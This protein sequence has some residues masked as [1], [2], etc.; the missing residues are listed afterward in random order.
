[1]GIIDDNDDYQLID[2]DLDEG[3]N[4]LVYSGSIKQIHIKF[5]LDSEDTWGYI[6]IDKL[7]VSTNL[8]IN[9]PQGYEISPVNFAF[10][11][12]TTNINPNPIV[13]TIESVSTSSTQSVSRLVSPFTGSYID[14]FDSLP[15]SYF[16]SLS[17]FGLA[18]VSGTPAEDLS[19]NEPEEYF[20]TP[21]YVLIKELESLYA[22]TSFG[23]SWEASGYLHESL[24]YINDQS[25]SI[26]TE[27]TDEDDDWISEAGVKTGTYPAGTKFQIYACSDPFGLGVTIRNF[28][29]SHGA[30]DDEFVIENG[31]FPTSE[32][33]GEYFIGLNDQFD[34]DDMRQ[35]STMYGSIDLTGRQNFQ[36]YSVTTERTTSSES[37]TLLR[38]FTT[39]TAC[40]SFSFSWQTRALNIRVTAYSYLYIDGVYAGVSY[41]GRSSTYVTRSG[42]KS[43]TYPAGTDIAI[44]G[45]VGPDDP[46]WG[47]G[48]CS[49]RNVAFTTYNIEPAEYNSIDI[50][51]FNGDTYLSTITLSGNPSFQF[52][53]R[54]VAPSSAVTKIQV[55]PTFS[56]SYTTITYNSLEVVGNLRDFDD[57]PSGLSYPAEWT[58]EISK[59]GLHTI[60]ECDLGTELNFE[61]LQKLEIEVPFTVDFNLFQ[62]LPNPWYDFG[63][64]DQATQGSRMQ[65][66][67]DISMIYDMDYYNGF[68]WINCDLVSHRSSPLEY[69]DYTT[70]MGL[71]IMKADMS[72][73]TYNV[74]DNTYVKLRL[75]PTIQFTKPSN[76]LFDFG[77]C[78]VPIIEFDKTNT[79][80]ELSYP[81]AS[82]LEEL[83]DGTIPISAPYQIIDSELISNLDTFEAN[84]TTEMEMILK[85][86]GEAYDAN[87][88]FGDNIYPA[89]DFYGDTVELAHFENDLTGGTGSQYE[90]TTEGIVGDNSLHFTGDDGYVKWTTTTGT[91]SSGTM[92]GYFTPDE[93]LNDDIAY[94]IFAAASNSYPS[95]D[96]FLRN[97]LIEAR[98]N[99]NAGWT[100]S[101]ISQTSLVVG[102]T[103]HIAYTWGP[104]GQNLYI[105]NVKED[106]NPSETRS[107]VLVGAMTY[108]IGRV[109]THTSYDG[110]CARGTYDEF[111]FSNTQ[112]TEFP[113]PFELDYSGISELY[114]FGGISNLPIRVEVEDISGHPIDT[115]DIDFEISFYDGSQIITCSS[116]GN[117]YIDLDLSPDTLFGK[118]IPDSFIFKIIATTSNYLT[119]L[120]EERNYE[121]TISLYDETG[122][123]WELLSPLTNTALAFEIDPSSTPFTFIDAYFNKD[124][125]DSS[126]LYERE[127]TYEIDKDLLDD[128]TLEGLEIGINGEVFHYLSN[129]E[130]SNGLDGWN[131]FDMFDSR[132]HSITNNNWTIH[133][134]QN[135]F[136][137]ISPEGTG[138][139][140][141]IITSNFTQ[142]FDET[143]GLR[144]YLYPETDLLDFAYEGENSELYYF[145]FKFVIDQD[146]FI[147]ANFDENVSNFLSVKI[148]KFAFAAVIARDPDDFNLVDFTRY[149]GEHYFEIEL[150]E[151]DTESIILTAELELN[152]NIT[153]LSDIQ[154]LANN[155]KF[156]WTDP[157]ALMYLKTTKN[158]YITLPT[159]PTASL[160]FDD[161]IAHLKFD[162]T[163]DLYSQNMIDEFVQ[164]DGTLK[165]YME[166]Q[167]YFLNN[168][169]GSIISRIN[170]TNDDFVSATAM[171]WE[172]E[173]E[174]LTDDIHEN[175]DIGDLDDDNDLD[176]LM[177]G[178]SAIIIQANT[179]TYDMRLIAY[180]NDTYETICDQYFLASMFTGTPHPEFYEFVDGIIP[181]FSEN[182][183]LNIV[184]YSYELDSVEISWSDTIDGTY[185]SIDSITIGDD[186][187]NYFSFEVNST[188]ESINEGTKY[189][190]VESTNGGSSG[191]SI[192]EA[193]VDK[194][195]PNTS[196]FIQYNQ[197]STIS[198]QSELDFIIDEENTIESF[199][200]NI[201]SLENELLYSESVLT[202][203]SVSYSL[204]DDIIKINDI[205]T[206]D[207]NITF[208]AVDKAG[209]VELVNET[210]IHIDQDYSITFY[211]DTYTAEITVDLEVEYLD[212]IYG[213]AKDSFDQPLP[214]GFDL[215]LE[216]NNITYIRTEINDAEGK[217]SAQILSAD[218]HS[219]DLRYIGDVQIIPSEGYGVEFFQDKPLKIEFPNTERNME[220]D[221]LKRFFPYRSELSLEYDTF[222]LN[223][224]IV[225]GSYEGFRIDLMV[226]SV[227]SLIS[228]STFTRIDIKFYFSVEGENETITDSIVYSISSDRIVEMLEN[229]PD[230]KIW[231]DMLVSV[232][233][234]N[235]PFY[236]LMTLS[237]S[238]YPPL[239]SKI[240]I[241]G[242]DNQIHPEFSFED[243]TY[244]YQVLGCAGIYLL[245]Q[246][247]NATVFYEANP[248]GDVMSYEMQGKIQD[249][250]LNGVSASIQNTMKINPSQISFDTI[251]SN[252]SAIYG[253]FLTVDG[254]SLNLPYSADV[255]GINV[256]YLLLS[257][258]NQSSGEKF[259]IG[260]QL[261]YGVNP[262]TDFM[263]LATPYTYN[264]LTLNFTGNGLFESSTTILSSLFTVQR[265]P[266]LFD[267]AT[268]NPNEVLDFHVERNATRPLSGLLL[269]DDRFPLIDNFNNAQN[270]TFYQYENDQ[271][272]V[273]F[274]KEL[275]AAAII[276]NI[277]YGGTYYPIDYTFL[278]KSE[279]S[280]ISEFFQFDV[281]TSEDGC[282]NRM[283]GT[284][285]LSVE[286]L[287]TTYYNST[288]RVFTVS[289]DPT[290]VAIEIKE[291][292]ADIWHTNS[293]T[294]ITEFTYTDA[295]EFEVRIED[296]YERDVQP[297]T[298]TYLENTPVWLEVGLIPNSPDLEYMNENMKDTW[299]DY[300]ILQNANAPSNLMLHYYQQDLGGK[301]ILY[302]YYDKDSATFKTFSPLYYQ[303]AITDDEGIAQF[304]VHGNVT[305][306]IAQEYL[307]KLDYTV[308]SLDS[309]I[310]YMRVFYSSQFDASF[311]KIPEN[312][313]IGGAYEVD[314]Y[315]NA[316]WIYNGQ[317]DLVDVANNPFFKNGFYADPYHK[318]GWLEGKAYIRKEDTM[319]SVARHDI[320]NAD[321]SVSSMVI[322]A[323]IINDIMVPEEDISESNFISQYGIQFNGHT[324]A[325]AIELEIYNRENTTKIID[326]AYNHDLETYDP[327]VL[328]CD[329]DALNTFPCNDYMFGPQMDRLIPGYYNLH[330]SP[331]LTESVYYNEPTDGYAE[332]E[333]KGPESYRLDAPSHLYSLYD[334][335]TYDPNT[336][337][338]W[339]NSTQEENYAEYD[340]N[341]PLLTGTLDVYSST[342]V[343]ET[344]NFTETIIVDIMLNDLKYDTFYI[345][346]CSAWNESYDF[347]YPLKF[348]HNQNL[349]LTLQTRFE[350]NPEANIDFT[351]YENEYNETHYDT[352][353]N[354]TDWSDWETEIEPIIGYAWGN[355]TPFADYQLKFSN[356]QIEQSQLYHDGQTWAFQKDFEEGTA[357]AQPYLNMT[358]ASTE[359]W[360]YLN[361]SVQNS[362][363][364]LNVTIGAEDTDNMIST[365]FNSSEIVI[366]FD[367]SSILNW[368]SHEN[369]TFNVTYDFR[370]LFTVEMQHWNNTDL[371]LDY[372]M[373]TGF[374]LDNYFEDDEQYNHSVRTGFFDKNEKIYDTTYF[375]LYE[376]ESAAVI[377]EGFFMPWQ[378]E[379]DL[380]VLVPKFSHLNY[381]NFELQ[382]DIYLE[383]QYNEENNHYNSTTL[384][385]A[386]TS[387]YSC[388]YSDDI[389]KDLSIKFP[390]QFYSRMVNMQINVTVLN[391]NEPEIIPIYLVSGY[392][393]GQE[394]IIEI[395]TA[396]P[397]KLRA[398]MFSTN[399]LYF[400]TEYGY[401]IG[402]ENATNEISGDHLGINDAYFELLG[403]NGSAYGVG[404]IKD[405]LN[406][407]DERSYILSGFDNG[408][409][410]YPAFTEENVNEWFTHYNYTQ[411]KR[412]S[413][414]DTY[415]EFGGENDT[416]GKNMAT[417]KFNETIIDD[418]ESPEIY[419]GFVSI[420]DSY[421]D[422]S[423]PKIR[424]T[425]ANTRKLTVFVY[426]AFWNQSIEK[427]G[428]RSSAL[429]NPRN[430]ITTTLGDSEIY[431]NSSNGDYSYEAD[432]SYRLNPSSD[433]I[434]IN[435]WS[436]E[437]YRAGSGLSDIANIDDIDESWFIDDIPEIYDHDYNGQYAIE[438]DTYTPFDENYLE[439]S[440]L[441]NEYPELHFD[442]SGNPVPVSQADKVT[443]SYRFGIEVHSS[444]VNWREDRQL[445]LW[446]GGYAAH[447]Y[448]DAGL[449]DTGIKWTEGEIPVWKSALVE[450]YG[451]YTE[452]PIYFRTIGDSTVFNQF[453]IV[454][455]YLE[456]KISNE[457][458]RLYWDDLNSMSYQDLFNISH[459][460]NSMYYYMDIPDDPYTFYL[461]D[462]RDYGGYINGFGSTELLMTEVSNWKNT[463]WTG[464]DYRGPV[465]VP[466]TWNWDQLTEFEPVY[467]DEV[468]QDIVIFD[469]NYEDLYN[470]YKQPID[471]TSVQYE[472][473]ELPF[474]LFDAQNITDVFIS[475]NY[476][477]DS[478]DPIYLNI[479]SGVDKTGFFYRDL[480]HNINFKD[481]AN[482]TFDFR[483]NENATAELPSTLAFG[484]LGLFTPKSFGI[485]TVETNVT[486]YDY[487]IYPSVFS[488]PAIPDMAKIELEFG[489]EEEIIE[490]LLIQGTE[491]YGLSGSNL[492]LFSIALLE[493]YHYQENE[494]GEAY[495]IRGGYIP[496]ANRTI[497]LVNKTAPTVLYYFDFDESARDLNRKMTDWYRP[498]AIEHIWI[499]TTVAGIFNEKIPW[500][501]QYSI[502]LNGDAN[503]DLIIE[504]FDGE[505]K[506]DF[507]NN[508]QDY[509]K[510]DFGAD[511]VWDYQIL[512]DTQDYLIQ[513]SDPEL[514]GMDENLYGG[515]KGHYYL[516]N[517]KRELIEVSYDTDYD[518]LFDFKTEIFYSMESF[519]L[520]EYR[521]IQIIDHHL[522]QMSDV[523]WNEPVLGIKYSTDSDGDGHFEETMERT[524]R[525]A[526]SEQIM[527]DMY[528]DMIFESYKYS[529]DDFDEEDNM[530]ITNTSFYLCGPDVFLFDERGFIQFDPQGNV[531]YNR[532]EI[533]GDF[534]FEFD[535]KVPIDPRYNATKNNDVYDSDDTLPE[536]LCE[537]NGV[538]AWY[539]TGTNGEKDGKMDIAFV[540]T[541]ESWTQ[542]RMAIGIYY[543]RSGSEQVQTDTNLYQLSGDQFLPIHWLS[544]S[545]DYE[546]FMNMAWED[547]KLAYYN[548]LSG[549]IPGQGNSFTAQYYLDL[550]AGAVI[551]GGA[552]ATG[553]GAS[554]LFGAGIPGV[555][556]FVGIMAAYTYYQYW[557][558]PS[559]ID[560][561]GQ[562]GIWGMEAELPKWDGVP[563]DAIGWGA[564]IPDFTNW[565]SYGEMKY[566]SQ[567]IIFTNTNPWYSDTDWLEDE[568]P[569]TH[570]EIPFEIPLFGIINDEQVAV[571][572]W[573]FDWYFTYQKS[574]NPEDY[575]PNIE[576]MDEWDHYESLL[577]EIQ[578]RFAFD[579]SELLEG[580][581]LPEILDISGELGRDAYDQ[582]WRN[583]TITDDEHENQIGKV[584]KYISTTASYNSVQFGMDPSG[585]PMLVPVADSNRNLSDPIQKEIDY[586]EMSFL[587]CYWKE[588]EAFRTR[589]PGV[590]AIQFGLSV[591]Q[592]MAGVFASNIVTKLINP[593]GFA[594]NY[595]SKGDWLKDF[596]KEILEE[597]IYE[598][599]ISSA[600][601][602][603]GAST[604]FANLLGEAS[605]S[606]SVVQTI[607]SLMKTDSTRA[608]I[609]AYESVSGNSYM[610]LS[611]RISDA[612]K[613]F[614]SRDKGAGKAKIVEHLRQYL[615]QSQGTHIL[616]KLQGNTRLIATIQSVIDKKM[617]ANI[618]LS[619]MLDV[620]NGLQEKDFHPERIQFKDQ[621][622]K[623]MLQDEMWAH[624]M[625]GGSINELLND[626]AFLEKFGCLNPDG[627]VKYYIKLRFVIKGLGT[628][629][630]Y[631]KDFGIEKLGIEGT[632]DN[633][634]TIQYE[635]GGDSKTFVTPDS[636]TLG[637]MLSECSSLMV[638]DPPVLP[639]IRLPQGLA[640]HKGEVSEMFSTGEVFPVAHNV[641]NLR[642]AL[643]KVDRSLIERFASQL[644]DEFSSDHQT[645][646]IP[647]SLTMGDFKGAFKQTLN[648]MIERWRN[649]DPSFK[650]KMESNQM[651]EINFAD[652]T[653][654][655]IN[656]IEK[657]YAE[658]GWNVYFLEPKLDV[659]H[660]FMG[661]ENKIPYKYL[662][663]INFIP[664]LLSRYK[665]TSNSEMLLN[666][667]SSAYISLVE[668]TMYPKIA[669]VLGDS[670]S[671]A[672]DTITSALNYKF[673]NQD[674]TNDMI[675]TDRILLCL[676]YMYY[677][678][679][680]SVISIL[681]KYITS[682]TPGAFLKRYVGTSYEF[683]VSTLIDTLKT[684]ELYFGDS[685]DL[686]LKIDRVFNFVPYRAKIRDMELTLSEKKVLR[687]SLNDFETN[688]RTMTPQDISDFVT[689]TLKVIIPTFYTFIDPSI[690][691]KQII[692]NV[693]T[694]VRLILEDILKIKVGKS[695]N[696][697]KAEVIVSQ[698]GRPTEDRFPTYFRKVINNFAN[699]IFHVPGDNYFNIFTTNRFSDII[700]KNG[701]APTFYEVLLSKSVLKWLTDT[702]AGSDIEKLNNLVNEIGTPGTE[703]HDSIYAEDFIAH[704][705][706]TG[707]KLLSDLPHTP[708][709]YYSTRTSKKTNL[710]H[711]NELSVL[712]SYGINVASF[713]EKSAF[714]NS[715]KYTDGE[716]N[717]QYS[718]Y[719]IRKST[720]LMIDA[721]ADRRNAKAF[722]R[723]F[724]ENYFTGQK[725]G[726]RKGDSPDVKRMWGDAFRFLGM[727]Y[728]KDTLKTIFYETAGVTNFGYLSY[729]PFNLLGQRAQLKMP[730]VCNV[731]NEKMS[732]E[733]RN[734]FLG[735]KYRHLIPTT[736]YTFNADGTVNED[737]DFY[738]S[739]LGSKIIPEISILEFYRDII[740]EGNGHL[741]SDIITD[742][743]DS[744]AAQAKFLPMTH[745]G[746]WLPLL[747]EA[748]DRALARAETLNGDLGIYGPF[749]EGY[750]GF[751]KKL[752]TIDW[753]MDLG[754]FKTSY[755]DR[756][757][758]TESQ[759]KRIV[760]A[761]GLVWNSVPG[762]EI[763]YIGEAQGFMQAK[764][765]WI[766]FANS[767]NE[768]LADG[769]T[770]QYTVDANGDLISGNSE[771]NI[772]S[773]VTFYHIYNH[774][775]D[776]DAGGSGQIHLLFPPEAFHGEGA[777]YSEWTIPTDI[778]ANDW[779]H[780][781]YPGNPSLHITHQSFFPISYLQTLLDNDDIHEEGFYG[782]GDPHNRFIFIRYYLD[783][784]WKRFY[785]N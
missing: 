420:S 523:F 163:I 341:Y 191:Y 11:D 719:D 244:S 213:I 67:P 149:G 260:M 290:D 499:N 503:Y 535:V 630:Y 732:V 624:T 53:I 431:I 489:S 474:Y 467:G 620:I 64:T 265:R 568:E 470:I 570:F 351:F 230:Q 703:L 482:I 529:T 102:R 101:L 42:S 521:R 168:M 295:K 40:T 656:T 473:L 266:T 669:Y 662:F 75:N 378:G 87:I 37:L 416:T 537:E 141:N 442:L 608:L 301:P 113:G 613:S 584:E 211:D 440:F 492:D 296:L 186:M 778:A 772:W 249:S 610:P 183:T 684:I 600:A 435:K 328:W 422:A 755:N 372:Q 392:V 775:T 586:L 423:L 713:K 34:I 208:Y 468:E 575:I 679:R 106:S 231:G 622:L 7:T 690:E 502:D 655:G 97:G 130:N 471:R 651:V 768:H 350:Y 21:D 70:F 781:L 279:E 475:I 353:T 180:N 748:D 154:L 738:V 410:D 400:F 504:E 303:M 147:A 277:I 452:L 264:D 547:S 112:R 251:S 391:S 133:N 103:Y 60:L 404:D 288:E 306:D 54:D 652:G 85:S 704:K 445:E 434:V 501:N 29:I 484:G 749:A 766:D 352:E 701:R 784:V 321:F 62:Y 721:D 386:D 531:L 643:T 711:L 199:S 252:N 331:A 730:V 546:T 182:F 89:L 20:S 710:F 371:D 458:T 770:L 708:S 595:N 572:Q 733:V 763:E 44:Y 649:M 206:P 193:V 229:N 694:D 275:P 340:S 365:Q 248:S 693:I 550:V 273:D 388:G 569:T 590:L 727:I 645:L 640:T 192:L 4:T 282:L 172:R 500:I 443:L 119:Y 117:S 548:Q 758:L 735:L 30:S 308:S 390:E 26:G 745:E 304:S 2:L 45:K 534:I 31:P 329:E 618:D 46:V 255:C 375:G 723:S 698:S 469:F 491:G 25:Q 401:D 592:T 769:P 579:N 347:V 33:S 490:N 581:D 118:T 607:N 562:K 706:F 587:S 479:S 184:D 433:D 190:K 686:G 712:R 360:S 68:E 692:R 316:Q 536:L 783:E 672:E 409:W 335:I 310:M 699:H 342:H 285:I 777:A 641:R 406:V 52:D 205:T 27:G 398:R 644:R 539:D 138:A 57:Y 116:D 752:M 355:Y 297:G 198:I 267:L 522:V 233:S 603:M 19:D 765:W 160:T 128:L 559:L 589:N 317:D 240:K 72:T 314:L 243:P 403:Y 120:D 456:V 63:E 325:F 472:Y 332:M 349:N 124:P 674:W 425:A 90:Y 466:A 505:A 278:Y 702:F 583:F 451:Y 125:I 110:K 426:P 685:A 574:N 774:M 88:E 621:N 315:E 593:V 566:S 650:A 507:E 207:L 343:N 339:T 726:D 356:L 181:E 614:I 374:Q 381:A 385:T 525:W 654:E 382:V 509:F 319:I 221:G 665:G 561:M 209:N 363:D 578:D 171:T 153:T 235:M 542:D 281:D 337:V 232:L 461:D 287:G 486:S 32:S 629:T 92:E 657:L 258:T 86:Y 493:N 361:G 705:K 664:Y 776:L 717:S 6:D 99:N 760:A 139:Y 488:S 105:N 136:L 668:P 750:I 158:Q 741:I 69:D 346:N 450:E 111:R 344:Y 246:I 627:T 602:A 453:D 563:E 601:Y 359:Y 417:L 785:I 485:L 444:I 202:T 731:P 309:I 681:E 150:P 465:Y 195:A 616:R 767:Y 720:A 271:Y 405:I 12:D 65:L 771:D 96:V 691:N 272:V 678:S 227:Y 582:F 362:V 56:K 462:T 94:S 159:I 430:G 274:E 419:S 143:W 253:D 722:I 667:P 242:I 696:F 109:P 759:A 127:F 637:K 291:G 476:A 55:L 496:E 107:L 580:L 152:V 379:I 636:L 596:G 108:G 571:A 239:I 495:D 18:Y 204:L 632:L 82:S 605:G 123:N 179:V 511:G 659:N 773:Q 13:T 549:F 59:V 413:N 628:I 553:A 276:L 175:I 300:L 577:L 228:G 312:T 700:S 322:E 311:M 318:D 724:A 437:F 263:I 155:E 373:Y 5:Y 121:L 517:L 673:Q 58:N 588:F 145:D 728:G 780:W 220:V 261:H 554:V 84:Y 412:V 646:T 408:E 454:I 428:I 544:N 197:S 387:D 626:K 39:T 15:Q 9:A 746:S 212:W 8:V 80:C 167:W 161:T 576:Y 370:N 753:S 122:E 744:A 76:L 284:Y 625:K 564:L 402:L 737:I 201:Y 78:V 203:S 480:K 415:L 24:L 358:N 330:L 557:V 591:I 653:P 459:Q 743:G 682:S 148:D 170:I 50:K 487:N 497:K 215:N 663:D 188:D 234:I 718:Y 151:S 448:D 477:D 61:D 528:E 612:V 527:D 323:D 74:G 146:N 611:A 680:S 214:Q 639:P 460:N 396:Y 757:G 715:I 740:F 36:S 573:V 307:N 357:R 256:D 436:E 100:L 533:Y 286:F 764:Q 394:N 512:F 609:N 354:T 185:T 438:D 560:T 666:S 51:L 397:E 734:L 270:V 619:H 689:H 556:S 599:S 754:M 299:G 236:E 200:L 779:S 157:N 647:R 289:I 439:I 28:Q 642:Q 135:T 543:C 324:D 257:A 298:R 597:T 389:W 481:I 326:G 671:V 327:Y 194:T 594:A 293:S 677:N 369:H 676:E 3:Y 742:L 751:F 414:F 463:N 137:Q 38:E 634:Y 441:M 115:S 156:V 455:D 219:E 530:L 144:Y 565:F 447:I 367:N 516:F 617:G 98:H 478:S 695:K 178:G 687:D 83:T 49:I 176:I 142:Y 126:S 283:P 709:V 399:Y 280:K 384:T 129:L 421:W 79:V 526:N 223:E 73:Y 762:A 187:V 520:P 446:I 395:S 71:N 558:R 615:I 514:Y 305:I 498:S 725:V 218:L 22:C 268:E 302:P 661:Y 604:G 226:P 262:S 675:A 449:F 377:S 77:R 380:Q 43:G 508:I 132:V 407:K 670:S 91:Y 683:R 1:M 292:F 189:F 519:A 14:G 174:H 16:D 518:G 364:F 250:V 177:D 464:T 247:N 10:Q 424:E 81:V 545:Y 320:Y 383:E 418:I 48:I 782:Y 623:E 429:G 541:E 259:D 222:D 334:F 510:M 333:L 515:E 134:S 47:S 736:H 196:L 345:E 162:C 393:M 635:R 756:L 217:F 606:F 269:T 245:D 729:K 716:G 241:T 35:Y 41:A 524:D 366:N 173:Q 638:I 427:T 688:W 714:V 114:E 739:P 17:D 225:Q 513:V 294:F 532:T 555:V 336:Y 648:D 93:I 494:T 552:S 238:F 483:F 697:P 224:T 169:L 707:A 216:L 432:I 658:M 140:E 166:T 506:G 551:M 747:H 368:T 598:E 237:D 210:I 761:Y 164:D 131:A 633:Y 254:I 411:D 104:T 631:P 567:N 457:E 66:Y 313:Y 376:N 538:L 585:R 23:Y 348:M 95:L 540:F 338:I 165:G 660:N